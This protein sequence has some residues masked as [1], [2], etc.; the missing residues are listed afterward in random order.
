MTW[1]QLPDGLRRH[2][3]CSPFSGTGDGASTPERGRTP[4]PRAGSGSKEACAIWS[5]RRR[6]GGRPSGSA[7]GSSGRREWGYG[8]DY[9]VGPDCEAARIVARALELGITVFDTAEVYGF[10]RSERI[11]GDALDRADADPA[12]TVVASK[13]F[14]LLPIAPVVEQRG[15]ASAAPAAPH[16]R[17]LPGPPAQPARRRPARPCP[18][19]APCRPRAS[20]TRSASRNYSLDRWQ[21]AESALGSRVI[22]NQVQYSLVVARPRARAAALRRRGR[23]R[24]H[25]LQPARAGPALGQVRR[26]T[27]PRQPGPLAQPALPARV[28]AP[29]RAA[30]RRRCARSPTPTT[31]RPRRSRWPG[32]STGR[33]SSPSPGAS[34]GGAAGE[35]LRRGRDRAR[36]RRVGG[37]QRGLRPVHA[38]S[39][40]CPRPSG[41]PGTCSRSADARRVRTR[42]GWSGRP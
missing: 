28:A 22:S 36:R 40:G 35:Q 26:R 11:L 1:G 41:S 13:I 7:P 23:A 8:G 12:T 33:R 10:G 19:C 16:A 38:R 34:L 29:G 18:A 31:R 25:R 4:C 17:P 32:R 39:A 24:R 6:S 37:A 2:G 14:P 9:A 15:V 27:P 30:D 20:S 21:D 5:S 42:P 3:S